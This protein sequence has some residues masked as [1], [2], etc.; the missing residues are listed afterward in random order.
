MRKTDLGTTYPQTGVDK[1]IVKFH[2]VSDIFGGLKKRF[3]QADVLEGVNHHKI[4]CSWVH[5]GD[6]RLKAC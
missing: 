2:S 5:D 1:L 6:V 3:T 4:L